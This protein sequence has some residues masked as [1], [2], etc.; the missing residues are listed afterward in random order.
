MVRLLLTICILVSCFPASSW[1]LTYYVSTTGNDANSGLSLGAAWRSIAKVAASVSAG[2]IVLVQDG[3]YTEGIVY[4]NRGGTEANRITIKAQNKW[5]ARIL[6]TSHVQG[7]PGFS[8]S[9]GWIR[10]DGFR[11]GTTSATRWSGYKSQN[12]YIH[13]WAGNHTPSISEP[14]SGAQGCWVSNNIFEASSG[15]D[16]AMK[17]V[18]DF[19]IVENNEVHNEIELF[20]NRGSI[21]R[22]NTFDT[23]GSAGTYIVLKGGLRDAL[24]YNNV[25][26]MT[27]SGRWATGIY[28]GGLTGHPSWFFDPN[29]LFEI[30]NSAVFN[31]VIISPAGVT[32]NR[33][34]DLRS[35]SNSKVFNNVII[36]NFDQGAF[37]FAVGGLPQCPLSVNPY[38]VNNV[39]QGTGSSPWGS[40]G[41]FTGTRTFNWNNITGYSTSGIPAQ[42]NQITGNPL[43]VNSNTDWHVSPNSPLVNAGTTVTVNRYHGGQHVVNFDADGHPRVVPWDLG[44]D[45]QAATGPSPDITPPAPPTGIFVR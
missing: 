39:F 45:E 43:F 30:Y 8:V 3:T 5:G 12:N 27:T 15:K 17:S 22:N 14:Y 19:T 4:F 6:T 31:N 34:I 24:V 1:A 38:F 35:D 10:F 33:A 16:N 37:L 21:M 32:T 25:I 13:C 9:A 23:G 29:G 11:F 28:V 36:G 41:Y 40:M 44:I 26:R 42:A 7:E 18:Q 20:N 2:D